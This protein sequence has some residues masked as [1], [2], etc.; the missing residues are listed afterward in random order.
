LRS[1]VAVTEDMRFS[2]YPF[3][4]SEI[5]LCGDEYGGLSLGVDGSRVLLF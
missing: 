1:F 4:A 2:G 5:A 3:I